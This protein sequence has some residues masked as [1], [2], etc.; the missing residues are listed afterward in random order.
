MLPGKGVFLQY[1]LVINVPVTIIGCEFLVSNPTTVFQWYFHPCFYCSLLSL[2]YAVNSMTNF[3][4]SD[5]YFV[6]GSL[7]VFILNF[8]LEH[9]VFCRLYMGLNVVQPLMFFL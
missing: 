7:E 1:L 2:K 6:P 5:L 8:I 4:K 3:I 9:L